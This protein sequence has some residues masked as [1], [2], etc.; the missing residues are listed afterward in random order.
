MSA[1]LGEAYT[2]C[3]E[4]CIKRRQALIGSSTYFEGDNKVL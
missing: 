1:I 2:K 4:N 3:M